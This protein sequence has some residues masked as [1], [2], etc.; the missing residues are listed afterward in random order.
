MQTSFGQRRALATLRAIPLLILDSS[1][2]FKR[3]LEPKHVYPSLGQFA[4]PAG[5]A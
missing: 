3:R 1:R 5:C 2:Q 4:Y